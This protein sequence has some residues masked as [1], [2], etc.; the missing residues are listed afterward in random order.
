MKTFILWS[1]LFVAL[2]LPGCT[3]PG[4]CEAGAQNCACKESAACNDGLACNPSNVCVPPVAAGVQV[5]E[6]GVRGCEVLLTESAGSSVLSAA[7]KNGAKGTF[8]RQPPKVALTF[9]SGGDS[10]IGNNVELGLAGPASG[11]S[12]SKTSCVDVKGQ[13]LT[14]TVSIR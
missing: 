6:A 13:R 1:A 4:P 11:I 3:C 14:A 7:F 5:S 9:V 2:V 8:I 10:A 12:V